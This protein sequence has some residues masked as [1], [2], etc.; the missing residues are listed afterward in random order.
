MRER[1][2]SRFPIRPVLLALL[3]ML[4]MTGAT[5]HGGNPA[6][7]KVNRL[8]LVVDPTV[9]RDVD[10]AEFN[11]QLGTRLRASI[12]QLPED[13]YVDLFFVGSGQGGLPADH[14][15]SLP[16]RQLEPTDAG[17]KARAAAL[18]STVTNLV[19]SR[20][21]ASNEQPNNPSSCILTA[22]YRAQEMTA[23]GAKRE[24]DVTLVV[25]SDLLEACADTKYN[26][27]RTIPDSIGAL[28]VRADLSG[29]DRVLMLRMQTSG[30]VPLKDET[31]LIRV[32]TDLL[33]RWEAD[34]TAVEF[35]PNFPE[36]LVT[37]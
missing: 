37:P 16:Y 27:E 17:H 6:R 11:R 26:F 33:K 28:P 13:T 21:A 18:A 35:T 12:A 15:D 1:T 8:V 25:V 2:I 20:W 31:R 29:A 5:C 14:R 22:L 7:D 9:L 23:L 10:A 36:T 3:V 4:S 32:W 19:Q 30:A 34:S 24:E